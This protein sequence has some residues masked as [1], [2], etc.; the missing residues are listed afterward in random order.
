MEAQETAS[1]KP[2]MLVTNMLV[3]NTEV[4][5]G[6]VTLSESMVRDLIENAT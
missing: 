1:K 6:P 5:V 4:N 2:W 3:F